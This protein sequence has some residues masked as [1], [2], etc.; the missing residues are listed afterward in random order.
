M[1]TCPDDL[2]VPLSVLFQDVYVD[3]GIRPSLLNSDFFREHTLRKILDDPEGALCSLFYTRGIGDA[4]RPR[5]AAALT[6]A[7]RQ[8]WPELWP[9][10]VTESQTLG[11]ECPAGGPWPSLALRAFAEHWLPDI[12][13]RPVPRPR[14]RS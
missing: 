7:F 11:V 12:P 10:V 9:E 2:D 5:V 8:R 6:A 4:L 3:W 1:S 13:L 14:G